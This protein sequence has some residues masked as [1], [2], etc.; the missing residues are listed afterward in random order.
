MGGLL[1]H[2]LWSNLRVL[3]MSIKTKRHFFWRQSDQNSTKWRVCKNRVPA[4]E[5]FQKSSQLFSTA[6]QTCRKIIGSI[7]TF[8]P[9]QWRHHFLEV[10]SYR[11]F[12]RKHSFN[13]PILVKIGTIGHFDVKKSQKNQ[14]DS[15]FFWRSYGVISFNM[16]SH[17]T[18]CR[19]H[20]SA[21][22]ILV[23]ISTIVHF[24]V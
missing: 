13:G 21:E 18:F 12:F 22:P 6:I 9:S 3:P 8:L 1:P 10:A 20:T 2:F 16:T 24:D 5:I 14:T 19:K 11:T 23:K 17:P 4:N 7:P 15:D